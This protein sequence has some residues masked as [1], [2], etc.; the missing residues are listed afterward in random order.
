M[1]MA[2]W[3]FKNGSVVSKQLGYAYIP[4]M[5]VELINE[6]NRDFFSPYINFHHSLFLPYSWYCFMTVQDY[7][8]C[9]FPFS[10]E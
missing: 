4:Q 1:I 8:V 6:F 3:S 7:Q 5:C 10:Q 9:G 2:S